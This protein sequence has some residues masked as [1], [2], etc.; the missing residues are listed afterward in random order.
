MF[1]QKIP[2]QLPIVEAHTVMG[3]SKEHAVS[4]RYVS[5]RYVLPSKFFLLLTG[6]YMP[7]MVHVV[8]WLQFMAHACPF[9]II[10]LIK[11]LTPK[12]VIV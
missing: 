6:E 1:Q 12:Q 2:L 3:D 10:H 8:L 5:I 4:N 11:F 7:T 9:P